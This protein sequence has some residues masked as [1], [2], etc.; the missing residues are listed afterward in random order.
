MCTAEHLFYYSAD[1][2]IQHTPMR[3]TSEIVYIFIT[4]ADLQSYMYKLKN[5]MIIY[6]HTV[7]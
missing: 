5:E 4:F 3:V 6:I 1:L 7:K 2:N